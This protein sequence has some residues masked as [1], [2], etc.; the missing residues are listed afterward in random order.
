MKVR[1]ESAFS[2]SLARCSSESSVPQRHRVVDVIRP[3]GNSSWKE[4]EIALDAAAVV[5]QKLGQALVQKPR[6]GVVRDIERP[7]IPGELV[8]E[9]LEELPA[10]VD[11]LDARGGLD[12]Q[13]G[14]EGALGGTRVPVNQNQ[15]A[16]LWV[17]G[18]VVV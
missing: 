18:L 2:G 10:Y 9:L 11:Q 4:L 8:A 16:A 13:C 17:E 15:R 5:L 12:P 1:C 7:G 6:G 3:G 14:V